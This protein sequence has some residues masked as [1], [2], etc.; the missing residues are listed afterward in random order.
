MKVILE[1]LK[2]KELKDAYKKLAKQLHPD[3]NKSDT[4]ADMQELN[5][6]TDSDEVFRSYLKRKHP[7]LFG[8]D[9]VKPPKKKVEWEALCKAIEKKFP[10][11]S[12][13]VTEYRGDI[14]LQISIRKPKFKVFVL[15]GMNQKNIKT[16]D[17]LLNLIN[18]NI[19]IHS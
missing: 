1:E 15:D 12:T 14:R 4:T 11:I 16:E 5:S 17:D 10:D 8:G 3:L 2:D 7:K 19:K 18:K 6:A 13:Y 9:E